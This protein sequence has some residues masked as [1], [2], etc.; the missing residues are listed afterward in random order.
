MATWND[1]LSNYRKWQ[2]K[3]F[4]PWNEEP[5]FEDFLT[6]VDRLYEEQEERKL[7]K[8]FERREGDDTYNSK[9]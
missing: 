8:E 4:A 3:N 1:Y 7:Q 2:E 6:K 5:E 9:K